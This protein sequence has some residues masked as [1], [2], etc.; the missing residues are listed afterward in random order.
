MIRFKVENHKSNIDGTG[1]FAAQRIPARKKIGQLGGEIVS[2][3]VA[4]QRI[5]QQKKVAMVEFG[6]GFALDA[7]INANALR[8]V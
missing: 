4:R 5:K 6:D 7:S 3:R 8:F 2:V 1:C